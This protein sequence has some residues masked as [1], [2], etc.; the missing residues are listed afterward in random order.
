MNLANVVLEPPLKWAGGK[1]WLVPT[2]RELR[3][4]HRRRR[5]VEPFAGALGATFGVAP[6]RAL[7]NDVNP[8]VMNFFM[9][10]QRGFRPTVELR[11]DPE[12]YTADRARFNSLVKAGRHETAEAASLFYLLNRTCFNGLTRFNRSGEFNV[13][14]GKYK[15]V[16][17][18]DNFAP[19][20][21]VMAHWTLVSGDFADL[22]VA[23]DDLL[24]VD[25][26]YDVEF[27]SYAQVDFT[28]ADQERLAAWLARHP[29]PVIA[30][31]QATNRILKL[32]RRHGFSI[33]TLDAPRRISCTGD[34]SPA[35]EM[36]AT[37]NLDV[38]PAA[39]RR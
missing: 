33:Q 12:Q 29:G 11:Y 1:R 35:R 24:Y 13:P 16:N 39:K 5:W 38:P 18:I 28:W 19:Y 26:P 30:S 36:L 34:R 6:K 10:L 22:D 17:F 9:Q 31:N 14:V 8:H 32:Y 2:L 20:Q 7:L 25:P 15:T 4:P 27:T 23:A 37:R 21:E 3:R